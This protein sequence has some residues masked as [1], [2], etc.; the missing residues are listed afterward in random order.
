MIGLVFASHGDMCVE[1]VK[2]AEMIAGIIDHARTVPLRPGEAPQSY[3]QRFKE[4]VESLQI[5]EQITSVLA[6]VDLLGGTPYNTAGLYSHLY[7]VPVITGLSLPMTLFCSMERPNYETAGEL[8]A[9]AH[10]AAKDGIRLIDP[11]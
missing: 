10:D 7:N 3:E 6:V 11:R 8:A 9:A 4:A 1:M 5:E 2:S